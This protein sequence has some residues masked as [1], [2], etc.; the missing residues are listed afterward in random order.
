VLELATELQQPTFPTLLR[1]FL[2]DQLYPD[3]T[4]TSSDIPLH[5]CPSYTGKVHLHRSAVATFHAP[6]DPSGIGGMR[7]EI[8]RAT[9]SWRKSSSRF[10]CVFLNRNPGL[11]AMRGMDIVCIIAFFSFTFHGTH[12]PCAFVHWFTTIS[13][14]PDEDTGMWIVQ[15]EMDLNGS[16][17]LSV[18][19]LDCVI[20]AAHLLGLFGQE[21]IPKDLSFSQSLDSF[22]SFYINRFIDHHAFKL[23]EM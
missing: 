12:Y 6:S 3:N 9:P 19:H 1:R 8:I 4:Q 10:D 5:D 16:P 21:F 2:Y 14:G 23:L 18:I 15:P 11:P 22:K 13:E 17:V 7:R 20:R